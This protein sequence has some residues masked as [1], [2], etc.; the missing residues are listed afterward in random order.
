M[1]LGV[2]CSACPRGHSP[3]VLD[4]GLLARGRWPGDTEAPEVPADTQVGSREA[5]SPRRQVKRRRRPATCSGRW[6][7]ASPSRLPLGKPTGETQPRYTELAAGGEDDT[8]ATRGRTAAASEPAPC[9]Q[10]STGCWPPFVPTGPITGSPNDAA[11]R[12][13]HSGGGRVLTAAT[14]HTRP[15]V[16][17][18]SRQQGRSS[19]THV[20]TRGATCSGAV[21]GHSR[22]R[23]R[24][25]A[26]RWTNLFCPG[27]PKPGRALPVTGEGTHWLDFPMADAVAF[28]S[29]TEFLRFRQESPRC[30][31]R[32]ADA[33]PP[34]GSWPPCVP[35]ERRVPEAGPASPVADGSVTQPPRTHC[36]RLCRT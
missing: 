21:V 2:L 31:D 35:S 23:R 33:A 24:A 10:T 15:H 11:L 14:R 7:G 20:R 29:Q 9:P 5:G 13:S 17:R 27:A 22:G 1:P 34:R 6:A 16:P 32:V 28:V 36:S 19:V 4:R 8:A 18:R 25:R 26:P 30:G 12:G 3:T